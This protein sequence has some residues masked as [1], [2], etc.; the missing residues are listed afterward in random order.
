MILNIL[1]KVFQKFFFQIWFRKKFGICGTWLL[2]TTIKDR[3]QG[4][5]IHHCAKAEVTKTGHGTTCG[6]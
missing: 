5:R 3:G 6:K 4:R 2:G 1:I